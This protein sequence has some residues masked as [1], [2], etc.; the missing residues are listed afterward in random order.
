MRIINLVDR[1]DRVN[2]GIWNASIATAGVLKEKFNVSSEIWFPEATREAEDSE[3]NGA[4]PRGLARLDKA[5]MESTASLA[6]LDPATDIIVSHGCWQYP[7]R[8]GRLLKQKGFA[9]LAVPHGMLEQWSVSQK[10]LRKWIYFHS[11]EKPSLKQA[12]KIRAVGRPELD[13]LKT[14]FKSNLVW[15]P[16][17][18][19]PSDENADTADKPLHRTVLFMARL[20]HKK[21]VLPMLEGWKASQLC[22]REGYSL[23][24]AGPDDGELQKLEQFL[25]VNDSVSNVEYLGPVYGDKKEA[26]LRESHFY[27]LPSYSEGFP[28]SVLEAMLNGLVPVITSGCNFPDVFEKALGIRIEPSMESVREAM[29]QVLSMDL[30]A[31]TELSAKSRDY[32]EENYTYDILATKQFDFYKRLLKR[33]QL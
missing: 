27:L 5:Q 11:I 9:W 16:N 6:G 4:L 26:L 21:G 30:A 1:L 12:D 17:G 25:K 8:W 31:Y 2:F 15:L 18:V 22:N 19:P 32:I 13:S 3:L 20:H 28:T 7:T 33:H 14:V 24:I 23:K 29:D 10:R